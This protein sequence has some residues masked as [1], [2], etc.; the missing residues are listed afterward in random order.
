MSDLAMTRFLATKAV[1]D[2]TFVHPRDLQ[3]SPSQF[4]QA[5]QSWMVQG[6]GSDF[7]ITPIP[8]NP[9][10]PSDGSGMYDMLQV[11]RTR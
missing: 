1:G 11:R 7:A 6:G 5:V 3:L 9:H 2:T 4:H 8:R 10:K